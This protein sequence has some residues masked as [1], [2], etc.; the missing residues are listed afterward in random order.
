M[1]HLIVSYAVPAGV[2]ALMLI[3]GTDI[4]AANF[5]RVAKH[6]RAVAIG[7]L[8]QI[9]VLPPLG[10]L[11]TAATAAGSFI[12]T[13]VLLLSLCPGGAI[14]NSY[15]YLARCNVSLSATITAVGTLLCLVSIPLWLEAISGSAAFGV[16]L[17]NVLASKILLQLAVFMAL[18]MTLGMTLLGVC[19]RFVEQRKRALRWTSFAIILA[20]LLATAWAV[21]DDIATLARDIV[22]TAAL[23]ILGAMLLGRV[24]AYG[25]NLEDGPVL[26]IES[27][28]RNVGVALI[29]GR[30]MFD[31]PSFGKFATFLTG[32]FVIEI[33]IMV[34]YAQVVRARLAR[35]P[36]VQTAK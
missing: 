18:P 33:M 8:G 7:A 11:V 20:I 3:A 27:A 6:P 2:F 4:T 17:P 32:Y 13:A 10:F 24:M 26:V 12:S 35:R 30:G 25:M 16:S 36:A 23:F 15:S 29:I 9:V 22:V 14:S 19:P 31:E 5:V 21:R 1:L 28:V 34:P